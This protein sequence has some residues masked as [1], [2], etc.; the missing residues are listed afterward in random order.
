MATVSSEFRSLLPTLAVT[1]LFPVPLLNFVHDGTGRAFAFAYLFFGCA[2]LAGE[3]FRPSR[4]DSTASDAGA[5][6]RAKMAALGVAMIVAATSFCVGYWAITGQLESS[7][8]SLAFLSVVPALGLVPYLVL[9]LHHPYVAVLF[10]SLLL[11]AVKL[12]GCVVVHLVYGPS[13][14]AEGRTAMSWDNPNLL[15]WFCLVGGML[16][17]LVFAVMGYRAFSC[18]RGRP[19]SPHG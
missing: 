14:L 9:R 3:C 19:Y 7:V 6:W 11:G 12:L 17:S 8:V 18:E 16:C 2:L 4:E 1:L 10:A 5:V 13:A 15:V